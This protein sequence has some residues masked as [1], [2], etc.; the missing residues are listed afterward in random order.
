MNRARHAAAL[1]VL[2]GLTVPAQAADADFLG[3]ATYATADGCSK[4]KALAAGGDRNISTVP[5]TLTA[6]G[7]HGWEHDCAFKS[8]SQTQSGASWK[9]VISCEEG[10]NTWDE[11]QVISKTGETTFE[12]KAEGEDEATV[13]AV[14]DAPP[15]KQGH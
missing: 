3:A 11:T 15:A 8:V 14:C 7:Y 9:V 13:Y 5:E 6:K 12:V 1:A 4:L 2:A 10:E